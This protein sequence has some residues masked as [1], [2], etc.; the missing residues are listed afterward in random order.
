[1]LNPDGVALDNYKTGLSGRDFNRK[2]KNSDKAV[3]PEVYSFKKLIKNDKSQGTGNKSR[4]SSRKT[5]EDNTQEP[6]TR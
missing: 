4:P 1:M 6:R 3:F 5:T 2:Y